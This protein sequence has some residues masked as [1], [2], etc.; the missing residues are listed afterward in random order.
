MTPHR[1][2]RIVVVCAVGLSLSSP[3]LSCAATEIRVVAPP[4]PAKVVRVPVVVH[5]D[6][7]IRRE[8]RV[9]VVHPPRVAVRVEPLRFVPPVDFRLVIVPAR[10]VGRDRL[11]WED[12][13]TLLRSEDWVEFTLDCNARGEKLWLEV[14]D[15]RAAVEWAEV[16]FANGDT[17]VVDFRGRTVPQ[18]LYSLLDFRD[19]RQVD[20][21]R[22]VAQARS[23]KTRLILRLEK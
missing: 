21:V 17:Q 3:Q 14:R 8:S 18:G 9:V 2:A 16:V 7:P 20:H 11:V 10:R 1:F 4:P 22:M 5:R 12:S 15:G 19:G 23:R 6:W 13:E